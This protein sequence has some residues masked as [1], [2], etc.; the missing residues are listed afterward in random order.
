MKVFLTFGHFIAFLISVIIA[1]FLW[2]NEFGVGKLASNILI[3]FIL[4][5]FL[6]YYVTVNFGNILNDYI[7]Y[8]KIR[9]RSIEI[10]ISKKFLLEKKNKMINHF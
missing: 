7:F 6:I 4:A 10:R 8:R 3:I 5:I 2:S 9:F 1:Y